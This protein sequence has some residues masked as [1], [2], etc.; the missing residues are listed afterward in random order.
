MKEW[1]LKKLKER[2]RENELK[3]V[4]GKILR[5]KR[6]EEEEDRRKKKEEKKM[7][8]YESVYVNVRLV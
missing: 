2:E 6:K 4:W 1:E 8:K 5:N 7:L 3:E